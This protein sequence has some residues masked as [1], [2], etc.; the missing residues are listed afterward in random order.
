[1]ERSPPFQHSHNLAET[2]V[3]QQILACAKF[4]NSSLRC[5]LGHSVVPSSMIYLPKP[6]CYTQTQRKPTESRSK[7]GIKMVYA[8]PCKELNGACTHLGSRLSPTK[9]HPPG[10][11]MSTG[12]PNLETRLQ[13]SCLELLS[14]LHRHVD[15]DLR[16]AK[17]SP[18]LRVGSQVRLAFGKKGQHELGSST[19]RVTLLPFLVDP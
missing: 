16:D 1:M 3:Q 10:F 15:P 19:S 6:G 2:N 14:F 7:P 12:V 18:P 5:W 9:L 17:G 13:S 11:G 4:V 8:K